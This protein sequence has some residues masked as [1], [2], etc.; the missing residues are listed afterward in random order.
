M[1][2]MFM[3]AFSNRAACMRFL[4]RN[5]TLSEKYEAILDCYRAGDTG[6]LFLY[7]QVE[8]YCDQAFI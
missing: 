7:L 5:W 2:N 8:N 6:G 4:F 3:V 1:E